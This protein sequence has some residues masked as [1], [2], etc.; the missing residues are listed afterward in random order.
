M[1]R[2]L[3][4][5][6]QEAQLALLEKHRNQGYDELSGLVTAAGKS[7]ALLEIVEM[8]ADDGREF[9]IE[10]MAFW[11]DRPNGDIRVIAE[12]FRIPLRP[13]LGFI[14]IYLGVGWS[15][16]FIIRPDGSFVDE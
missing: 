6:I 2:P 10:V 16:C 14:P 12:V 15:E 11:D 1:K 8:T 7:N 13:L 3:D 5:R 9:Q 4:A